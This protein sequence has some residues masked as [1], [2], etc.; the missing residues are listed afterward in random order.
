MEKISWFLLRK[1]GRLMTINGQDKNLDLEGQ[2][3][4]CRRTWEASFPM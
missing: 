3:G 1:S 2:V 4:L